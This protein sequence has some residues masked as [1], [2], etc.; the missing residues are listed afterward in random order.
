MFF[1]DSTFFLAGGDLVGPGA[2]AALLVVSQSGGALVA[3]GLA[4]PATPEDVA[5]GL[6]GEDTVQTGT[7]RSADRGLCSINHSALN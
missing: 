6:I 5:F 7:V 2:N 4:V 3:T 1:V